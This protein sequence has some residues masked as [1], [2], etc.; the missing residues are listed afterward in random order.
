MTKME[1]TE[2]KLPKNMQSQMAED[3]L[4]ALKDIRPSDRDV[5]RILKITAETIACSG[6][7]LLEHD[8]ENANLEFHTAYPIPTKKPEIFVSTFKPDAASLIAKLLAG[9]VVRYQEKPSIDG[10]SSLFEG[11]DS[12]HLA[13]IPIRSGDKLIAVVILYQ[14]VGEVFRGNIDGKINAILPQLSLVLEVAF[15]QEEKN[16]HIKTIEQEADI[17]SRIDAELNDT[18]EL[19]HVFTM[20]KDWALRFSNADAAALALYD[21]STDVLRIMSDYGFKIGT[22][23]INEELPR[24]Q[25][26]ITLRVARTGKAEVVPDVTVDAD[27]Y[28]MADNMRT[29]MSVPIKREDNVIG[30]LTLLSRKINGFTDEHLEFVKRL[31]G[32]AGVAIDNARLFTETKREREK[33]SNIVRNIGDNVILVGLDHRIEMINASAIQAFHLSTDENYI[34]KNLVEVLSHRQLQIAY[35]DAVENND[36]VSTEVELPNGRIYYATIEYH[37]GIGRIIVMQDIMHFKETDRLKTELVATVS[38]DLKQPLSVMRGYMDLL[39]MVNQFDEKSL[40]YVDNLN[41]AFGNMQQLIDDLLDV[42]HIE[43]GITLDLEDVSIADVL[44]RAVR[45]NQ[46]QANVKDIELNLDMPTGVPLISGDP[47][48][49]EQIFNN[50]ISNGVKY[51]PNN[52]EVKVYIELKQNL[53]RIFIED[54]GLGIGSEDQSQ[55]FERFY[56]VRRPE[57]DNIEGTGLG[58]AIVKSLVEAHEGKIEL[59][60]A[61]GEG[62]TFR[63]TL[64]LKDA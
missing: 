29:Q 58:L 25:G 18:I 52:G 54:N 34:G 21:A 1:S 35:Q 27:Y 42:A 19:N 24:D 43:A 2:T 61:L 6:A 10:L 28:A 50:L 8:S 33:L 13:F 64:P 9:N 44:D 55:I 38:H 7:V 26:G 45:S 4:I 20:M 60:S 53:V 56:R 15:H 51:T 57:T 22:I 31:S 41:F 63:V 62:S 40:K 39:I 11:I 14:A 16:Q 47:K 3:F 36:T 37:A 59:K 17:L 23:K 30:V 32:R 12:G 48:R 49:L 5:S 46:H